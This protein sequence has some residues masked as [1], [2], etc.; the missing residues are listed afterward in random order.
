MSRIRSSTLFGTRHLTELSSL[1]SVLRLLASMALQ[2]AHLKVAAEIWVPWV[3]LEESPDGTGLNTSGILIDVMNILR[4]K[5]NF[6]FSVVRPLD[7]EWGRILPNGS[8]TGMIGMNQRREVDMALGP[9]TISYDRAKVADYAT[10]IH[11]DNF[12]IFLPRPRL[13]KDLSGFTKPFA[14]QVWVVLGAAIALSMGLSILFNWFSRG[15]IPPKA[16]KYVIDPIYVIKSLLVET[17]DNLPEML[18]GR[19]LLGVWLL[20][21]L[22]VQSAYQGVLT[23]MLAVPWVTVPVDSLDDLGRQTRIP[24]AF[25]S[26]THLHFLFQSATSGLFKVINDNAFQIVSLFEEKTRMKEQRFAILCDFFSMKKVMSDDFSMTAKCNYYIAKE[27][28]FYTSLSFTF[29]KKS[30]MVPLIDKW[31]VRLLESGI[32]NRWVHEYSSNATVCLLPPGKETGITT[33]V[34]TIEDLGG[35]FLLLVA[36]LTM[37]TVLF[38]LEKLME[39][40]S[41]R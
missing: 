5:L 30:H 23:S 21:A 9:F 33:K 7:G 39:T 24:Y 18:T 26:G 34:L 2:G 32:V 19:V 16:G 35:I 10:T 13:E 25:E 22:I 31:L 17:I 6:T 37:A 3:M 11:L 20:A 14:W 12:G 1:T 4:S 38:A 15:W 27:P 41:V 28:M 36:G 29:P 40:F 8:A